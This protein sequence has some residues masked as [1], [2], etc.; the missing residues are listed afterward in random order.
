MNKNAS[1][2]V[3]AGPKSKS[4][5]STPTTTPSKSKS[6]SHHIYRHTNMNHTAPNAPRIDRV[7]QVRDIGLSIFDPPTHKSQSPSSTSYP[8]S[9][10]E[11]SQKFHALPEIAVL[12]EESL[13]NRIKHNLHHHRYRYPYHHHNGNH[14]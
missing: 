8:Y 11:K 9:E 5:P 14:Q 4:R 10:Y 13:K 1:P 2:F 12:E 7:A 3:P 6:K